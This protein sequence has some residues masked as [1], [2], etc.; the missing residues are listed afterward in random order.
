MKKTSLALV[1]L[2]F[3][4]LLATAAL[5]EKGS[6]GRK[7]DHAQMLWQRAVERLSLT[8]EQQ[9]QLQPIF[10]A[11]FEQVK[12][13]RKAARAKFE[14]VLTPAQKEKLQQLIAE[15]RAAGP[16]GGQACPKGGQC[17]KS[18]GPEAKQGEGPKAMA[19]ALSLTDEQKAEMKK[20]REENRTEMKAQRQQFVSQVEAVLTP[21]QKTQFEEMISRRGRHH[22]AKSE[23]P[24]STPSEAPTESNK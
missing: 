3:V 9:T 13:H 15:R 19:T 22:G 20:I 6:N 18:G 16:K 7:G 2:A 5:A 4:A 11:H 17:P 14:A 23:A 8:P 21:A 1:A 12:A 24:A 10:T